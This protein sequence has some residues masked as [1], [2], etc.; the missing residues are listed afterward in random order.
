MTS[1]RVE[2]LRPEAMSSAT[3]RPSRAPSRMC[4]GDQRDRLGVVQPQPAGPA[5]LGHV[6]RHMDQQPLLLVRGQ[7]HGV[8]PHI[9]APDRAGS[10]CRSHGAKSLVA[11]MGRLVGPEFQ[12]TLTE[13]VIRPGV[14]VAREH[15]RYGSPMLIS[16]GRPLQHLDGTAPKRACWARKP[17]A[18]RD[19]RA[20]HAAR[21]V[22]RHASSPL[23]DTPRRAAP[24]PRG[25][26][27]SP[28][29]RSAST[30]RRCAASRPTPGR[31]AGGR[32]LARPRR[33][34]LPVAGCG[35]RT[36][37]TSTSGGGGGVCCA[38]PPRRP[39]AT[40]SST[41]PTIA[42][43]QLLLAAEVAVDGPGGEIDLLQHVLHGR[44][45]EAVAGEAAGGAVEDLT[46]A[47]VEV[48]LGYAGHGPTN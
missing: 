34:R 27:R 22:R 13:P 42:R 8:P 3:V 33:T 5:L 14:A 18:E 38:P 25:P 29:R 7:L 30:A 35:R 45:M 9:L 2:D 17:W 39:R 1:S 26:W 40:S 21:R 20:R 6:G 43:D 41:S 16:A 4:D 48:F 19:H 11:W 28:S 32:R 15:A 10:G 31:S 12:A 47:G 23:P 44:G 36:A 46:A 37:P 24:R